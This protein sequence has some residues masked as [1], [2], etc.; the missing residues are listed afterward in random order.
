MSVWLFRAGRMGEFEQKFLEDRRVYLTWED[1]NVDLQTFDNKIDL[2]N[3]LQ[4][5]YPSDKLGRNRNWTGQ[6]WPIAH[7]MQV[8]DW[9]VL[10]SK[11][12]ASIH[13]GEI[14][15]KYTYDPSLGSPYYH[16]RE[17]KWFSTDVPRSIFD[18]DILNSLGAFMTVCR[19]SRNDAEE[20]LKKLY[21]NHWKVGKVSELPIETAGVAVEQRIDLEQLSADEIGKYLVTK[22]SGHNMERLVEGILKAQGYTTYRSP[23]GPDKGVDILAAPGPLGFGHPRLCVQVK[24]GE[25]PIDRPTLDQLIGTMQNMNA[26]QG[27]LVSLGGFRTSIDKE[28]AAQ[29]FRVRLWDQKAL[30]N[31]LLSYYDKL[32]DDLRAEVP[33]KRIWVIAAGEED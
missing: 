17:V 5:H 16:Y 11:Y 18:Q 33:L 8:G 24:V 20:R 29:F 31:E 19:I 26:D 21:A 25:S 10:P 13:F 7:E 14:K 22:F 4:A 2:Y 32:D 30:I 15:G 23:E 12:K 3:Y 6:I 27:L 9:V 1:L 28:T